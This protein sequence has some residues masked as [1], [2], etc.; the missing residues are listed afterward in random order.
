MTGKTTKLSL[1][2][3]PVKT[4]KS[5]MDKSLRTC[6]QLVLGLNTELEEHKQEWERKLKAIDNALEIR[7]ERDGRWMTDKRIITEDIGKETEKWMKAVDKT[8]CEQADTRDRIFIL[9]NDWQE[10]AKEVEKWKD[11]AYNCAGETYNSRNDM[12]TE[13]KKWVKQTEEHEEKLQQIQQQFDKE[14]A[15]FKELSDKAFRARLLFADRVNAVEDVNTMLRT[16]NAALMERMGKLEAQVNSLQQSI[17]SP[18]P[19][20]SRCP[21]EQPR[22]AYLNATGVPVKLAPGDPRREDHEM[23]ARLDSQRSSEW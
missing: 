4:K 23:R 15:E 20:P 8:L 3:K 17:I 10:K 12:Y 7:S 9:Y 11:D 22:T 2:V 19:T 21:P 1:S 18:T 14:Y 5:D 16:D 6:V 13:F